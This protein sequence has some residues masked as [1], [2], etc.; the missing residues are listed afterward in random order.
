MMIDELRFGESDIV[1]TECET[2]ESRAIDVAGS[3]AMI[4]EL[5]ATDGGQSCEDEFNK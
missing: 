5:M 4:D 1:L 2:R 3:D